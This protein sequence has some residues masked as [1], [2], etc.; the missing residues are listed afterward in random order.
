MF[1]PKA[2]S[3]YKYFNIHIAVFFT[4]AVKHIS[5]HIMTLQ[6]AA[7]GSSMACHIFYGLWA[8]NGFNNFKQLEK[9]EEK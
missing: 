8:E 7:Q 4:V 9:L 3:F 1:F 5:V 6:T 2:T